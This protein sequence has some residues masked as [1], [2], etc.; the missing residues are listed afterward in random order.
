MNQPLRD[1][2]A[3]LLE[4]AYDLHVH[5]GLD[6]RPRSVDD[7]ELL[8]QADEYNMAGVLIKNHYEPTQA[9]AFLANRY[10]NSKAVAY[11]SIVLNST[12]GGLNPYAVENSLRQGAKMV[13]MPTMDSVLCAGLKLG[14][15]FDNRKA[16][17]LYDS[18]G[19]IHKEVY[20]ILDLV[21]Q[22]DVYIASGHMGAAET[23]DF[24]RL[25]L[26]LGVKVIMTHPDWVRSPIPVETQTE[27]A[28]AGVLVEKVFWYCS[29][30]EI[31]RS[32]RQVGVTRTFVVTDRG[33]ADQDTPT[34]CLLRY[35]EEMLVC[36]MTEKEIQILIC[37]VPRRIIGI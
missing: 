15:Q 12:V 33:Q 31:C 23:L 7:I 4:G 29:P 37:E 14:Q 2:A 18:G 1:T 5:T 22:Y 3:R 32:A 13:W 21:K 34:Q 10:G 27:M 30:E 20:E 35:V 11:G 26:S 9:R 28:E 25:A 8:Q 36:G 24:C 16:I 6:Y 19:K 17:S